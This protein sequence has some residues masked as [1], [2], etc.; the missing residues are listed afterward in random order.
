MFDN[1]IELLNASVEVAECSRPKT[2]MSVRE[3]QMLL[4]L[5]KTESYWVVNKHLFDVRIIC[6]KM[7]IMVDSFEDWYAGQFHYKKVNGE[8]PGS[9]WTA[10]SLSV[11]EVS[12]IL[13]ISESTVYDVLKRNYFSYFKVD[14]RT[15]IDKES[16]YAWFNNQSRYP[17]PKTPCEP[18]DEGGTLWHQS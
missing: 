14:N 3:M 7:R 12:K 18:N 13:G 10:I 17:L 4:G 8:A 6:G 1:K 2:S 5:C 15:R 11:R 9:K 16:F